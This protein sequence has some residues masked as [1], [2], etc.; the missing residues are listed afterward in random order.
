MRFLEIGIGTLFA[1]AH[2]QQTDAFTTA[3]K[4]YSAYG[5]PPLSPM[6]LWEISR[7]LR[8]REY[9]LVVVHPPQYAAWHPRSFLNLFQY[10]QLSYPLGLFSSFAVN[11]LRCVRE[12][13][14]VAV[15]MLD[16]FGIGRHNFFLFDR[17]VA[18]YKRELPVDNWRVF[19]GSGHR[20]LPAATFRRKRRYQ[21]YVEKIRPIGLGVGGP[22]PDLLHEL[23]QV[24]KTNDV[25]YAG[26]PNSTVRKKGLDQL[27]ALRDRG[28]RV[29]IP[30]ER[31]SVDDFLRRCAR[32]W[33]VWSPEGFGWECFRHYESAL[34][35]SV[36]VMNYPTI[37]RY[38]PLQ[39][40]IHCFLY[41]AEGDGLS[42]TIVEA[43]RNKSRLIQMAEAGRAHA[44][45]FHTYEG[46]CR[47]IVND[48]FPG[49]RWEERAAA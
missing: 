9:D 48:V 22:R 35:G 30:D 17:C 23:S 24:G 47:S 11:F 2:P 21:R 43:L 3:N 18:Y 15:D 49:R 8:R 28:V 37:E 27:L 42:R 36:P 40:G 33:L 38:R 6:A 29:D 34:V 4:H 16:S 13:P 25:F 7:R 10:W 26:T 19:F 12:T 5:R 14:M 41:P 1:K 31:L 39:D 46:L 45:E 20:N 32:S 44:R